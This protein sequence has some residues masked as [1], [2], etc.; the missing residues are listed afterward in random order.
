MKGHDSL[1]V[2]NRWHI[3]IFSEKSTS[4]YHLKTYWRQDQAANKNELVPQV[5]HNFPYNCE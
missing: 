5:A 4:E 3:R 1:L 2:D